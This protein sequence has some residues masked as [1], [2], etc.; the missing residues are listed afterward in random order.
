MS[1]PDFFQYVLYLRLK[2]MVCFLCLQGVFININLYF[3]LSV[4]ETNMY[5]NVNMLKWKTDELP[6]NLLGILEEILVS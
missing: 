1:Y 3:L 5:L 2:H 4:K 6:Y